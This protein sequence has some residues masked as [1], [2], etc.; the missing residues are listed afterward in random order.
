MGAPTSGAL[1]AESNAFRGFCWRREVF[2]SA[3]LVQVGSPAVC[4]VS[5][6]VSCCMYVI[7]VGVL[8]WLLQLILQLLRRQTTVLQGRVQGRAG[9]CM[10]GRQEG[11]WSGAANPA[12]TELCLCLFACT[13]TAPLLYKRMYCSN[14]GS[15]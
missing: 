1:C 2:V 13:S 3:W 14:M 9:G 10:G 11:G 15:A 7:C 4:E 5:R 12:G 6:C 8:P